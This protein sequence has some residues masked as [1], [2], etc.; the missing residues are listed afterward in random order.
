MSLIFSLSYSLIALKESFSADYFIH[1]DARQHIFW[2]QRFVDPQL[3]PNDWI[4]DYFQSLAPPGYYTLYWLFA[5][6]G[7]H[8]YTLAKLLPTFLGIITTLF[9]FATCLQILPVPFAGFI[10]TVLL[11]QNL[12]MQDGLSSGTPRSFVF[13]LAFLFL[14]S[15]L[16]TSLSG[17]LIS[18]VLLGLFYPSFVL[19]ASAVLILRL[20]HW[21]IWGWTS[22]IKL[23]QHSKQ[24]RFIGPFLIPKLHYDRS[25]YTLTFLGLAIALFVLA[26][27]VL[28][29]KN[30]FGPVISLAQASTMPEFFPGGR[31][32]FF[33]PDNSWD[34]WFNA[35][36]SG[37]KLSSAITSPLMITSLSL[38][39]L[40][41]CKKQIPLGQQI[42]SAVEILPQLTLASIG[43]FGIAHVALFRLYLPSRYTQ[44][45]FRIVFTLA[46]SI[47]LILILDAIL[48]RLITGG[49]VWERRNSKTYRT[50]VNIILIVCTGITLGQLF[51]PQITLNTFPKLSYMVG[52][53]PQLYRFFAQQPKSS[54]I[55]SLSDE[56]A[57]IPTFSARS[58]LV[59]PEHGIPYHVG[60][61]Q[62]FQQRVIQLINTQYSSNRAEIKSFLDET[63]ADFWLI[64]HRAFEIEYL[65]NNRWLQQFQP[66]TQN[67]IVN[68]QKGT[69]PIVQQRASQCT[70]FAER[71]LSV[72]ETNCL[73]K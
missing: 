28:L 41:Q 44:Y 17:T 2:M 22:G 9:C 5:K 59:S 1:D 7:L 58:V 69:E 36:R 43:L 61:Y 65:V 20:W 62:E 42:R 10:A 11:N 15:I 47:A 46:T 50:L 39:I 56:A 21:E 30:E 18:I 51:Y 32:E 73:L 40:L 54:I 26:P 29:D 23:Q 48:A 8:P 35:S 3:F 52:H 4:A 38:P 24:H 19:V 55:A 53:H 72:L 64:D 14:Y 63:D 12:W 6:L 71:N 60:Y 37:L 16:R 25:H 67:A 27:Q 34:F 13:P 33:K 70:I 31:T 57:N 68:L 49:R 45:S 66:A